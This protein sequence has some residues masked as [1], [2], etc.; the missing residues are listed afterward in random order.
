MDQLRRLEAQHL[1]LLRQTEVQ[2]NNLSNLAGFK[3]GFNKKQWKSPF[4]HRTRCH[5][6]KIKNVQNSQYRNLEKSYN[7]CNNMSLLYTNNLDFQ[8]RRFQVWEDTP[9]FR[10]HKIQ[11][12]I[13]KRSQ[14]DQIMKL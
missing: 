1:M 14:L 10:Q 8:N 9:L 13:I 4:L 5:E 2:R 11:D 12:D 3:Q 6:A 7:A